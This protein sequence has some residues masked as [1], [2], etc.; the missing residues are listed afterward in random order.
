[1]GDDRLRI[2]TASSILRRFGPPSRGALVQSAGFWIG[3]RPFT[4]S[5]EYFGSCRPSGLRQARCQ[6]HLQAGSFSSPARPYSAGTRDE[7]RALW[8]IAEPVADNSRPRVT[9]RT[10]RRA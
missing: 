8:S 1:M 5:A 4:G 9:W 3:C 6:S 2:L 10:A 7:G